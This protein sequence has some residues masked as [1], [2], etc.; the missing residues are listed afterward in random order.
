MAI[1]RK[2][3]L[4]RT[5]TS[6]KKRIQQLHMASSSTL[7]AVVSQLTKERGGEI[8]AQEITQLP[9]NCH[10]VLHAR[11][12]L[13]STCTYSDPLYSIIQTVTGHFK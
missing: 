11:K 10:Q 12:R 4:F 3:S 13:G 7:K 2:G 1:Q 5:S 8:E 9:C 6:I